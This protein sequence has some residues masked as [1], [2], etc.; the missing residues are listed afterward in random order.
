MAGVTHRANCLDRES[1]DSII[2]HLCILLLAAG[3]GFVGRKLKSSLVSIALLCLIFLI[4][5]IPIATLKFVDISKK[6]AGPKSHF[7]GMFFMSSSSLV[8]PFAFC[9]CHIKYRQTITKT[10]CLN[11]SEVEPVYSWLYHKSRKKFLCNF[12]I[13]FMSIPHH[14]L[15]HYTIHYV[16]YSMGF[17]IYSCLMF[18]SGCESKL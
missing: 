7:V 13:S 10:F 3:P 15:Y 8:N 12:V 9:I 11:T 4:S 2:W 16:L 18:C 1:N 17:F 5:W 6:D 14:P